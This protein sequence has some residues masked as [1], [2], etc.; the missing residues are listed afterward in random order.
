MKP[1]KS[2]C[3][4]L[5]RYSIL[6]VVSLFGISIL[7][8]IF[9]PLTIYPVYFLLNLFF[10]VALKENSLLINNLFQ[11]NLIEACIAESAYLLLLVFNLS[12]PDI[13]LKK[14]IKM[15]FL[16]FGFFLILNIFRI[17]FLSILALSGSSFFD[18]THKVFWY[19]FSTLF[20]GGI[21]F[22]EV[23]LFEI[24]KIPFYS[25][26]KFLYRKSLLY[27]K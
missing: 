13:K 17:F 25:D 3:N 23:K 12:V 16:S 26:V 10:E 21:W 24:K 2:F 19:L 14:R 1:L 5:T 11:I 22:L 27:K 8:K 20:V 6:L 4:I 15:I 18:I 7:Y 9:F